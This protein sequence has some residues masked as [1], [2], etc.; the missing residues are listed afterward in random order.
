MEDD[1]KLTAQ[2]H[3]TRAAAHRMVASVH[4]VSAAAADMAASMKRFVDLQTAAEIREVATHP[5]LA[6]LNLRLDGFYGE[7]AE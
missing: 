3:R 5:D 7:A 2:I 1:A 4:D 6:E